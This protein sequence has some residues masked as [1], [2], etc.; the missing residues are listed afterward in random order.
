MN[1]NVIKYLLYAITALLLLYGVLLIPFGDCVTQPAEE[2]TTQREAFVWDQDHY[3]NTLGAT[4]ANLK[5]EGCSTALPAL[6]SN[7]RQIENILD[8]LDRSQRSPD[9]PLFQELESLFFETAPLVSACSVSAEK[10]LM[11]IARMRTLVK[12]QSI[13]WKIDTASARSTLYRLLYGT[14]AAAEELILQA[15]KE[16]LPSLLHGRDE[17]SQTPSVERFGLRVHSG[18]ILVSR[19]GAPTSALIARGNDYPGNFSHIALVYVDEETKTPYIIEA[20]IEI[21]VAV[22]SVEQYFKD[23]K[24]RIM[25][26]RP[27]QDLPQLLKDPMIPHKAAKQAY[28]K[29]TTEHIPYDFAMDYADHQ[30]LF[31]SEVAS[32]AY[33]PFGVTLWTNISHISSSGLRSWLGALGVRHFKTQEPSDLEYDPQLTVVAEWYD[34]ETLKYDH[35]DNAVTE[36]MLEGAQQGEVLSYK[37]YLLPV[38]R[39]SKAYSVVLNTMGLV[40]PVPEGMSSIAALRSMWYTERHAALRARLEQN[41]LIFKKKHGYEP[42]YW[43]EVAMVRGIDKRL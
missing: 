33:E 23:K 20:H 4:F 1:K 6:Q 26:L 13:H 9:D 37:W 38:M 28:T 40:G 35:Y 25:L 24:L 21:G 31:C 29:A 8:I 19:G 11:L 34:A 16:S 41:A 5:Q 30:K 42:P 27:R 32:A 2:S 10:Y 7:L 36:V 14:R 18:D 39:L 15:P 12:T 43:E 3:W 17:R 22:S